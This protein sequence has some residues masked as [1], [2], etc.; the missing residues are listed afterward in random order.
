MGKL[1]TLVPRRQMVVTERDGAKTVHTHLH[2]GER[3]TA[4]DI[5]PERIVCILNASAEDEGTDDTRKMVRR[6]RRSDPTNVI[7]ATMGGSTKSVIVLAALGG[8]KLV[9][10][11]RSP[12]RIADRLNGEVS[13]E[14]EG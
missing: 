4:V 14:D 8:A 12:S 5:D 10:T 9:T 6:R 1:A 3:E 7:D 13:T 11:S 2:L